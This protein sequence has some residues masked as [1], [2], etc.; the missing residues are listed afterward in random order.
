MT[1]IKIKIEGMSCMHCVGRVKQ[2]LSELSGISEINVEIGNASVK[3][4]ETKLNRQDIET[5]INRAGYK[6]ALSS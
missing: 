5:A 6:V 2:A 3:Y 4:D 1:E